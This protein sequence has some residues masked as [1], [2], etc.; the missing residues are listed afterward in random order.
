MAKPKLIRPFFFDQ[1]ALPEVLRNTPYLPRYIPF[2]DSEFNSQLSICVFTT[3]GIIIS[4]ILLIKTICISE[5]YGTPDS[6][7]FFTILILF[8][9]CILADSFPRLIIEK[10]KKKAFM[11]TENKKIK[12]WRKD[13]KLYCAENNIH[14][15]SI[16]SGQISNLA[17]FF[18]FPS[19]TAMTYVSPDDGEVTTVFIQDFFPKSFSTVLFDIPRRF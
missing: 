5:D 14:L 7:M 3:I 18:T 8:L 6:L 16:S 9:G 17:D 2:E 11:N 13:F 15:S 10:G 1:T 12:N 19:I 4:S